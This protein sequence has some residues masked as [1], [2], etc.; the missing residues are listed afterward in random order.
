MFM[1]TT[2][3]DEKAITAAMHGTLLK[4]GES[5]GYVKGEYCPRCGAQRV[6]LDFTSSYICNGYN[7]HVDNPRVRHLVCNHCR[8]GYVD[9]IASRWS[10]RIKHWGYSGAP[11]IPELVN[12]HNWR[13]DREKVREYIRSINGKKCRENAVAPEGRYG[14]RC[15]KP[16]GHEGAHRHFGPTT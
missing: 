7:N 13:K 2:E 4:H 8:H 11:T 16:F 10:L 14:G 12:P 1:W 9:N 6:R 5:Y 15:G 3:E